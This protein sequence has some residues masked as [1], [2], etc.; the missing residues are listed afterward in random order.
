M[1][2][3][4]IISAGLTLLLLLNL[5]GCE[6]LQRKFTRKTKRK[7]IKP[8]FYAEGAEETRPNLELYMMH[9]T[10]WRAWHQDLVARAGDNA[11]RDEMASEEIIGHLTDMRKYLVNGKADELG[12]YIDEIRNLTGQITRGGGSGMR[13]GYLKRK[14]DNIRARIARKFYYKKVRKYLKPD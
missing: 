13:L 5:A 7:P 14:L 6:T 4:R 2:T 9:Y 3:K 8:M 1:E 12:V 10:Y 11:K